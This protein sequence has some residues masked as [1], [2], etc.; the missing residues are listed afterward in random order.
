MGLAR[1]TEMIESIEGFLC[2]GNICYDIQAWPVDSVA[3]GKSIWVDEI[4][5]TL[6]GNGGNTSWAAAKLGARVRLTG[7][8]GRD[9]AGDRVLELL[10]DAGVDMDIHRT[11][12]PTTST[13]VLVQSTSDRSFLHRPGA[14]RDVTPDLLRFDAPSYSH[15]HFANPFS[16]PNLRSHGGEIMRRA[17]AAGLTTSL[18]TAWDAKGRWMEDIAPCLPYTDLLFVNDSEAEMLTGSADLHEAARILREAGATDVIIKVG[19]KGCLLFIGE[20]EHAAG[21]YAVDAKDTTGAGDCFVGGFL[22][23]LQRGCTYLESAR[24]ANAAGALNVQNIGAAT[25]VSSWEQT[26]AWMRERDTL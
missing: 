16:L 13:V 26:Q 3:W 7:V 4:G 22:A 21:G 23:A 12:S 25:G 2:C 24:I 1:E 8:V 15:F 14:S 19:P 17:R 11:D 18:D 9:T 10:R 20:E 6:G 5:F